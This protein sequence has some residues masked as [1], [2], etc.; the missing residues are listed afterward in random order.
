[1]KTKG[2]IITI[3]ITELLM[4]TLHWRVDGSLGHLFGFLMS[5]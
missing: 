1:M 4:K 5:V 3:I 2:L